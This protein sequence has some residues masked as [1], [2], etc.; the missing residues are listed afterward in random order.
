[1]LSE[2]LYLAND[3]QLQQENQ[4]ARR[5]TRL[6]NTSTEEDPQRMDYVRKLFAKAGEHLWVEPPF[7]CDY[8][9][10]ITVGDYFYANYDCIIIDV[11]EVTLGDYVFFGPRV[12]V[13][14]AGHP[15]DAGVR[16]SQL[17]YGKKITVGSHVW[18]GGNTVLNPGVT[19]GDN[20]V[21][22][23]GSVVTR[24][25]PSGVVAAGNPCRVLRRITEEDRAYWK[26]RER[27][28]WDDRET[29]D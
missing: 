10:H 11:C 5:V 2:E 16:D 9:C 22:G 12:S 24:D 20:V 28:Y 14:T 23:S 27:A 8:G 29:E 4:N 7:R 13:Y 3:R 18:V 6:F 19:V 21:I 25:I 26:A 1:M 15:I 17:E